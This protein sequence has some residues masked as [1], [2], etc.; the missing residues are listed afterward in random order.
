MTRAPASKKRRPWRRLNRRILEP[1]APVDGNQFA[2]IERGTEYFDRMIAAIAAS[3]EAVDVE[4]YLWDDD[5]IGRRFVEALRDAA[6]RG[7]RVRVLVDAHGAQGVVGPLDVVARAGGDVRVFN[8]FNLPYFGRYFH[9]THKKLLVCDGALAFTGGAGFSDHWSSKRLPDEPWHDWMFEVRGPVVRDLVRLFEA[10][11]G[12]WRPRGA[13]APAAER[14]DA[15][16]DVPRPGS[17]RVRVLR[18]WPDARDF[19]AELV[20]RVR[21]AK[22]RVWL[23]TPYFIPPPS[24][25]RSLVAAARRGVD[26][27]LVVPERNDAH[28]LVWHASR[29]HYGWL[30]RRGARIHEF[31]KGFY[32]AK[33]AVIDRDAAIVGSSNLDYWSWSRNAEIDLLATDADTVELVAACF[34]KDLAR[35]REV[36]RREIGMHSWFTRLKERA[37]GWFEDWL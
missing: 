23:G 18:G 19:R 3:A 21:A 33:L 13:A 31:A 34:E 17:S 15:A 30:L 20:S 10:D 14:P 1:F 12:R 5:E 2:A 9:R 36:T 25:L 37:A 28:P 7:R 8:P 24:L 35:S 6:A 11:F 22:E 26:V 16:P 32:H 27:R 29:R 4:M